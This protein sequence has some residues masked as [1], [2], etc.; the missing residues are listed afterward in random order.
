[1]D[2]IRKLIVGRR[3]EWNEH[4]GGMEENRPVKK[5]EG[6]RNQEARQECKN[7]KNAFI[8]FNEQCFVGLFLTRSRRKRLQI[9]LLCM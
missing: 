4:I 8:W 7:G 9:L 5:S 2:N 6:A 1:M 3:E